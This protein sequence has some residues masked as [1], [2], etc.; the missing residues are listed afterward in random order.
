M[1]GVENHSDLSARNVNQPKPTYPAYV[2]KPLEKE[3]EAVRAITVNKPE[4]SVENTN[5]LLKKLVDVPCRRRRNRLSL[6]RSYS[7]SWIVDG[8]LTRDSGNGR[9]SGTGRR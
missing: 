9:Y 4:R 2:V 3:P 8:C 5:E 6:K 1:Q 7:L